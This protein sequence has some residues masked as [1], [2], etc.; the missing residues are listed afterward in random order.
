MLTVGI[1]ERADGGG[2][3]GQPQRARQGPEVFEARVPVRPVRHV[4][5]L[6]RRQ[7]D[8]A[9]LLELRSRR[10]TDVFVK[11]PSASAWEDTP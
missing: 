1:A 2:P 5:A 3:V 9:A 11:A 7:A 4:P 6:V 10:R 8:G